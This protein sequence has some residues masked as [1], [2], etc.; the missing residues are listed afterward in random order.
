[1]KKKFL[2]VLSL[3][4][5]VGLAYSQSPTN[6]VSYDLFRTDKDSFLD[7]NRYSEVQFGKRL[8]SAG[9]GSGSGGGSSSGPQRFAPA[10]AR[11]Q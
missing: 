11:R 10:A 3:C 7:V 8:F 6:R 1:M 9:F 4:L 5:F 2:W